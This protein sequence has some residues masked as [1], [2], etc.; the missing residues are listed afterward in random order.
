MHSCKILAHRGAS[1]EAP[2]NTRAAFELAAAQGADGIETDIR[3]TRDNRIVICHDEELLRLTGT[4]GKVSDFTLAKLR[5]LNFAKH[6]GDFPAEPIMTLAE[7]LTLAKA[8]NF[9]VNLEVKHSY[10][11]L[12]Q[13][14]TL[15]E[16]AASE[17]I[18]QD[19]VGQ[20]I[21]SSFVFPY[22]MR[23]KKR[24]PEIACAFLFEKQHTF[25]IGLAKHSKMEALH[26]RQDLVTEAYLDSVHEAGLK[27]NTW[28]VNEPAD[29]E[30]MLDIGVDAIITNYPARA[31]AYARSGGAHD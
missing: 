7:L 16:E 12:Y 21:F 3:Y 30:Q 19:M 15:A 10:H 14:R 22:M 25:T 28:T 8:A 29:I 31:L 9:Y 5:Q 13:Y 23:L 11:A 17:V 26:P 6:F 18:K 24:R 1:G 27:L 4:P 2:E 20:V